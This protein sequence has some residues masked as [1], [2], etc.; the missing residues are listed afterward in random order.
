[1]RKHQQLA[2]QQELTTK[3]RVMAALGYLGVFCLVPLALNRDDNYVGF[4]TRQGVAIWMVEVT[5]GFLL[6]LPTFGGFVF[7]VVIP[8]CVVVSLLGVAGVVLGKA[9]RFP[10]FCEVAEFL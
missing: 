6:F 4:H 5:A 1:M 9:W 3:S 2:L 8:I 7:S 10:F